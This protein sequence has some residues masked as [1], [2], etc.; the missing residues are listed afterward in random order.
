MSNVSYLCM[1]ANV[2]IVP[3]LSLMPNFFN[4]KY[5]KDVCLNKKNC[6]IL[7][8]KINY[9]VVDFNLYGNLR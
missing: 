9:S 1:N 4:I 8:L 3:F 6:T 7:T 5:S 2:R